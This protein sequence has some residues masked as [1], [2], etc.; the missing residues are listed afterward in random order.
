MV[1][2]KCALGKTAQF[3]GIDGTG[4]VPCEVMIVSE[5]PSY[6]K[7]RDVPFPGESGKI[8]D[9]V[10]SEL[11]IPR[12]EIYF[13]HTVRCR[14]PEN[15]KPRRS[16]IAECKEH[17][18]DE[19]KIVNPRYILLMGAVAAQYIY[20]QKIR[21]SE[22]RG[23]FH[24]LKRTY[25]VTISPGAVVKDIS[26]LPLFKNDVR[27]FMERARGIAAAK[28]PLKVSIV[29]DAASFTDLYERIM[30]SE[31]VSLDIETTS[32]SPWLGEIV[33][34]GFGL[35][36]GQFIVPLQH[37]EGLWY[38]SPAAQQGVMDML[39]AALRIKEV[40]CHNGKFDT[41]WIKVKFGIDIQV[42]H[43][44]MM[45]SH[46]LD[47]NTPNGLKYLAEVYLGA[48]NYDL[49][50]EQKTGGASL[51]TLAN[52][53]ALD[54][55]YTKELF[56]LFEPELKQ[57]QRLYHFYRELIMPAVNVFRDIEFNGVYIDTSR[58]NETRIH[59]QSELADLQRQLNQYKESINWNSTQQL[60][61][62][63]FFD[64]GLDP[65]DKTPKG[66]NSTSESVLKRL[67]HPAV[68]LILKYRES[69]KH[70][71]TFVRSW[72][73]K[74]VDSR[75]HPS[76][77]LHGTVTGRLSCAE[78]NLQQVPRDPKIRSLV[79]APEGYTFVEADFSQIELRIAA[80]LSEDPTMRDLFLSGEDI[81][82][83][84]ARA[85][86]HED[87][88][89][90]SPF[91]QK[92]WRKKAKAINFGFLY[93]MGARKFQE[94]A[95]DKYEIDFTLEES[96]QIRERFFKTYP[97]LQPWY[98]KQERF[99]RLNSYVKGLTGRV[100]H[101]PLIN[102]DDDYEQ[103]SAIRQAINSPV[104][105]FASDM[106]IM[107]VIDISRMMP[108]VKIVGTVH[109]SILMEIPNDMVEESLVYIK[110]IM[111]SPPTLKKLG[112]TH[113]PLPIK[114]DIK[115]GNWGA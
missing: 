85:V 113:L 20:K 44:T 51:A 84:T 35:D 108:H 64:L 95:R 74:H 29:K 54:V 91:E 61:Q 58:L 100:R 15:R 82:L 83:K 92:E 62:F 104:Q 55:Y 13:T 21:V 38:N 110:K 23:K 106:T 68:K 73:E 8:L 99:V 41:L 31:Y 112:V 49:T 65:L 32:L 10:L 98:K 19:V 109:D 102:S 79:T 70:L 80:I 2:E 25:M 63:L 75:L 9:Q 69:S 67:D 24:N 45:M 4:P 90:L 57:D 52:Y 46:L 78:P 105:G 43:D 56:N 16:E 5:A 37:R 36:D 1:C 3:N 14:P 94:Y 47:E 6:R 77:K 7:E 28:S 34:I 111:E 114:V 26:K 27:R 76:F 17:L 101:L 115:T 11:G 18:R 40:I 86:S 72:T 59:L 87:V 97:G 103:H 81:H 39:Y 88:S 107:S 48:P 50:V 60:A 12:S 33:S 42:A 22:V 53:N 30:Q 89:K 66:A 96:A 71:G 93:G